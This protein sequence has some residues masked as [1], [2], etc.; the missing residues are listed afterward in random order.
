MS[1]DLFWPLTL[2]QPFFQ[3]SP[4]PLK[5][6]GSKIIQ[7]FHWYLGHFGGVHVRSSQTW[8]FLH[9]LKAAGDRMWGEQ[10]SLKACFCHIGLYEIV[11]EKI[12]KSINEL[13]MNIKSN[14]EY[15]WL[16]VM[17]NSRPVYFS[18][19][20]Q[21]SHYCFSQEKG[22][23]GCFLTESFFTPQACSYGLWHQT[24]IYFFMSQLRAMPYRCPLSCDSCNNE[25]NIRK[26]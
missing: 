26:K 15:N 23:C 11:W 3:S 6:L 17:R 12:N 20:N 14:I 1:Q 22:R 10:G 19:Y 2:I 8:S 24:K 9:D 4:L 5:T 21:F 7:C 18:T 13:A 16:S 25:R